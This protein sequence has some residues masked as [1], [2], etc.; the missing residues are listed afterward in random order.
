MY[1]ERIIDIIKLRNKKILSSVDYGT[2]RKFRKLF[3]K[4]LEN[5]ILLL[6]YSGY[7]D[8]AEQQRMYND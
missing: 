1:S 3:K 2:A 6:Y 7:R 4:A 5:D 8:L